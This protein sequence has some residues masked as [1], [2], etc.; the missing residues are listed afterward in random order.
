VY[1]QHTYIYVCLYISVSIY[2][3]LIGQHICMY[4]CLYIYVSI[5]V[6]VYICVSIYVGHMRIRK[7]TSP[8][9]QRALYVPDMS[10][11]ICCIQNMR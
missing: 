6:C 2:V 9:Y 7:S 3:G 5:Y 11:Y 8:V 1:R 4:V 10:A